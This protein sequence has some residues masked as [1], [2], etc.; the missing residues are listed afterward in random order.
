MAASTGMI[1]CLL[2]D[3]VVGFDRTRLQNQTKAKASFINGTFASQ[4]PRISALGT[5]PNLSKSIS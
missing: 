5:L 1:G 2:A 4:G 3:E